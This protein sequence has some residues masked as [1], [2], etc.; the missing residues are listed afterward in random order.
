[1]GLFPE[2]SGML[3]QHM[4]DKYSKRGEQKLKEQL[5]VLDEIV[6]MSEDAAPGEQAP[7]LRP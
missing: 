6:L 5:E 1:M 3:L 7:E 2:V 4:K